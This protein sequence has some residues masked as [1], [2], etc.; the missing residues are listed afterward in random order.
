MR[1]LFVSLLLA[2][3]ATAASGSPMVQT[4]EG[5]PAYRI[6]QGADRYRLDASGARVGQRIGFGDIGGVGG[7]CAMALDVRADGSVAR[8]KMLGSR[9]DQFELVCR[10]TAYDWRL[11]VTRDGT[12]VALDGL[13]AAIIVAER[14]G[15]PGPN[16]TRPFS[17]R[18]SFDTAE[19]EALRA[20]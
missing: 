4:P 19:I 14:V 2:A 5:G 3:C 10:R 9:S 8:V 7:Y 1:L 15:K 17:T 16:G 18:V 6:E 20:R 12:P 13:Q 11:A